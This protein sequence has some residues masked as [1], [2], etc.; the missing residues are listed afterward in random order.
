MNY[1]EVWMDYAAE[2]GLDPYITM[3]RREQ[4]GRNMLRAPAPAQYWYMVKL[5]RNVSHTILRPDSRV[6]YTLWLLSMTK[7]ATDVNTHH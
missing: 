1:V 7:E 6:Q 2:Y 3:G 5:V 4:A